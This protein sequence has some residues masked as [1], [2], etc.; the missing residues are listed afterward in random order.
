M[1]HYTKQLQPEETY[2]Q[3]SAVSS[4]FHLADKRSWYLL[5]QTE[6]FKH[7]DIKVSVEHERCH[8]W[9]TELIRAEA[10]ERD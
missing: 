7:I 10:A 3:V 2:P 1:V 9:P 8:D 5:S 4:H 6:L